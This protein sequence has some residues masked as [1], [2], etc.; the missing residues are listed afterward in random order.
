MNFCFDCKFFAPQK[1]IYGNPNELTEKNLNEQFEGECRRNPPV[2]GIVHPNEY[3]EDFRGYGD[4][5]KVFPNCWC[6]EFLPCARAVLKHDEDGHC[7][8]S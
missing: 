6:G 1:S 5:P 2:I 8:I 4:F 7:P 3:D